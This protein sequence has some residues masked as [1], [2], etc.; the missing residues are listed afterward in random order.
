MVFADVIRQ[1]RADGEALVASLVSAYERLD[2]LVE[3]QVLPQMRRLRVRLA[4]HFAQ[5]QTRKRRRL[6][7]S[8][9]AG[10]FRL[11]VAR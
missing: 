1:V 8:T 7:D 3:P 6:V 2:S 11:Q 4:A 9:A 5:M 10:N